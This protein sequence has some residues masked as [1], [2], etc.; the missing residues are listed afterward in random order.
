MSPQEREPRPERADSASRLRRDAAGLLVVFSLALACLPAAAGAQATTAALHPSLRPDRLGASA[1]FTLDLHFGGGEYDVPAP[2]SRSVLHLPV[3]LELSD[4][5][6]APCSASRLRARGASGC[7]SRSLIG[8]GSALADAPIGA[9]VETEQASIWAFL[10]PL[11]GA[12]PTIEI[13]VEGVTPLERRVVVTG[14]VLPDS[15]PYGEKL[16][17]MVPAIPT[18][19]LEPD[20][21]VV[22]FSLTVGAAR[23]GGHASAMV[24]VPRHCPAG[25]FPFLDQ[26]SFADGSGAEASARVRCP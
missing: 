23:R 6:I 4:D 26:L 24:R 7:S 15:S 14:E 19:P 10:G 8:R 9:I 13:L 18:I 3:G 21:S 12:N 11:R 2:L 17:M 16:V 25:G 20:A 1:T 5:H 22:N